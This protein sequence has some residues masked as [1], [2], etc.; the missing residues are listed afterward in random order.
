MHPQH[1]ESPL[2]SSHA[3]MYSTL[4]GY[5]SSDEVL[6]GWS[7]DHEVYYFHGEP[8]QMNPFA[9]VYRGSF[10]SQWAAWGCRRD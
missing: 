1:S 2:M 6:S 10:S 8:I 9:G 5:S 4:A 3:S 7:D